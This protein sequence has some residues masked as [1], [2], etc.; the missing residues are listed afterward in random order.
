MARQTRQKQPATQGQGSGGASSS[1]PTKKKSVN[2][3]KFFSEVRQ[4]ARK[5]TWTSWKETYVS[6]IMVVIF[7]VIAGIFFFAVDSSIGAIVKWLLGL[8]G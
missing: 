6:T 8:G 3:L 4:E 2:P 5:V 1:V 7:A